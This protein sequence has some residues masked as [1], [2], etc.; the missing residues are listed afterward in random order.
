[1]MFSIFNMCLL[2]IGTSSLVKYLF[3]PFALGKTRI[4]VFVLLSYVFFKNIFQIYI[5]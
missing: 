2:A 4:G 5:L 3:K 1:M